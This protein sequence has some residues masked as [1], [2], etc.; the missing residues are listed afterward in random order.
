MH[1]STC[2]VP[3]LPVEVAQLVCLCLLTDAVCCC[4]GLLLGHQ[5]QCYCLFLSW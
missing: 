4:C 3:L 2:C 1:G 5:V